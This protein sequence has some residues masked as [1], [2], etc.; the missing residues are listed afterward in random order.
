SDYS[1]RFGGTAGST[2]CLQPLCPAYW[3]LQAGARQFTGTYRR[4][5][6]RLDRAGA[7][8]WIEQDADCTRFA[9]QP[10]ALNGLY[11]TSSL[12][13]IAPISAAILANRRFGR[14]ALA[15]RGRALVFVGM[16]LSWLDASGVRPIR[17]IAA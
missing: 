15:E 4:T 7:F 16:Q 9:P 2:C 10:P 8:L 5:F 12:R 14:R 11:E 3:A 17:H 6:A 1:D 13:Q